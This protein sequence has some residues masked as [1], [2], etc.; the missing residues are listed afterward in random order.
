MFR[1]GWFGT[2]FLILAIIGLGVSSYYLYQYW[3][4]EPIVY[5]RVDVPEVI[6]D[7]PT[8]P[9]KQFY[10]NMRYADKR[11]SYTIAD[12]CDASRRNSMLEALG[13]ISEKTPLVF[14]PVTQGIAEISVLCSNVAP[15]ADEENHFV[16]GEG[17]PAQVLNT[18]KYSLIMT[19]K[20]ALYRQDRCDG[21]KVA[22]HELLH[23]LGFDH[24]NNKKSILY[25]TLDCAQTID[26]SIISS[27]TEIYA[28]PSLANFKFHEVTAKNT[29]RYLH[30]TIDV[31]NEGLVSSSGP[32]ILSVYA[33]DKLIKEF[34]LGPIAVGARKILS[35][36]NLRVSTSAKRVKFEIDP[37]N[38]YF[39]INENDNLAT[40]GLN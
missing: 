30:F 14:Y 16:A 32:V 34:E 24:N 36:E 17:G 19:G 37:K 5:N 26:P 13:I 25:P 28:V 9:S 18:T 29:G 6:V 35:V 21:A 40:F 8:L 12:S 22:T 2:L 3:P 27:I 38:D 39:E 20:I 15:Q 31:L 4:R 33:D 10:T 7:T 11:I 1:E 23:A